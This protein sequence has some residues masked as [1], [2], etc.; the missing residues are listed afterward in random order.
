M[1]PLIVD[2]YEGSDKLYF[3]MAESRSDPANDPLI[4]WL[5]GGPG[6]SS[7]LGLYT[8]NG[9]FNFKYNKSNIKDPFELEY[10]EFSWNNH[11]NVMYVDQPI[12]T[13]FSFVDK[14]NQLR[15]SEDAL[16][17]DFYDFLHNFMVKYPEFQG[18]DIY[19]TGES[20]AG[21]YIPNIARKLQLMNDEWINLAGIAIGNGWVDPFYQYMAYP[22][23]ASDHNLISYGHSLVLMFG[24][25]ICQFAIIF[26]VPVIT[27][28][29][30]AMVGMTI[31]SPG[32]P[33]FNVYDIRLPCERMGLCYPDDHLWQLLNTYEY[34][35]VMGIPA[36]QGD[37][38]EECATLPH[39]T[40]MVDFEKSWGYNLAPLLDAGLPVLIYNGD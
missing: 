26:Q 9:P 33:N 40:L 2:D 13:G 7:M 34:R 35:E 19:I 15:W 21:H 17:N 18:R 32:L 29:F 16:S 14:L 12:G 39:L 22:E 4:I 36:E 23:F 31:V 37:L 38:W 11:A 28:T 10:N 27:T 24:Y 8:E 25:Q 6:C 5:Q 20:Y 3:I 30:C 1:D